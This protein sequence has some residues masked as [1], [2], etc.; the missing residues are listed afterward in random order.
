MENFLQKSL[1]F[2]LLL[3]GSSVASGSVHAEACTYREAIMALEQGNAVRGMA[4]M[5]MANR[6]G[7]ERA[8]RYLAMGERQF[9]KIEM[10]A[11]KLPR[12]PLLS[13]NQV[14]P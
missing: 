10:A 1:L 7:D 5:R 13:L 6:D 12:Q 4:L 2:L 3:V 9:E 14:K 11:R 8:N